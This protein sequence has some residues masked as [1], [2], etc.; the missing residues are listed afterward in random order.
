MNSLSYI[1]KQ[2]F[3]WV[4]WRMCVVET[5]KNISSRINLQGAKKY[6]PLDFIC[7]FLSNPSRISSEILERYLITLNKRIIG[8]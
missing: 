5:P 8:I 4:K 6:P 7:S 2:T 1:F 3:I